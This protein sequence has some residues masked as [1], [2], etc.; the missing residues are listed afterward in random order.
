[1]NFGKQGII[2]KKKRLNSS[3][4]RLGTKLGVTVV[5][6]LFIA[7]IAVIV[8]GSCLALGAAEG[9]IA[10]APDV[11][12][13]DVSPEGYATKIYDDGGN[14][15]QTLS[16]SGSN[17]IYVDVE[18]IPIILQLKMSVSM[19]ITVLISKVSFVPERF[20]FLQDAC[21]KVQVQSHSSFLK[22]MFSKHIMKLPLKK[23]REKSRNSISP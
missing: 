9:I 6:L 18:D 1:M 23:S 16:T 17:R 3:G 2:Q 12:T 13:I 20:F 4:S 11:S 8:A 22:I 10:S 19:N 5:K 15:I 21:Q 7:V 14:E